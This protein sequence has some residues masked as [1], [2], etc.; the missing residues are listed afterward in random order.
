MNTPEINDLIRELQVETGGISDGYHTF[1]ELYD[2]RMIYHAA[3]IR[4]WA[5]ASM[6]HCHKSLKH[7]DGKY[8]FDSNGEWFIVVSVLPEGQIS[9]HYPIKYWSLFKCKEEERALFEFDGHTQYDAFDRLK[10]L[11]DNSP[12]L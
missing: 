8:C 7:H 10:A 9:N 3:L 4:E 6:F 11:L 2:F 12:D 5:Y 1:D